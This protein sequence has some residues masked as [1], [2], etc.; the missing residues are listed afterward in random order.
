MNDFSGAPRAI[1]WHLPWTWQRAARW[2]FAGGMLGL[3]TACSIGSGTG[4]MALD[5]PETSQSRSIW[6]AFS[7]VDSLQPELVWEPPAA[8]PGT[9]IQETPI[10]SVRYELRIWQTQGGY[11]GELVYTRSALVSNRHRVEEPLLPGTRYLWSVRAEYERDGTV[12]LTPWA[13]SRSLLDGTTV[14]NPACYRFVTPASV[15]AGASSVP[16]SVGGDPDDD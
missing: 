15:A 1:A 13:T 10:S 11:E 5:P 9:E 4:L 12:M 6:A 2:V 7:P 3:M 8:D 16:G 14:P